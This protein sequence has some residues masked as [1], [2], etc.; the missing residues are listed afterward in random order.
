VARKNNE[1][2]VCPDCSNRNCLSKRRESQGQGVYYCSICQIEYFDY[3][4]KRETY[5][6]AKFKDSKSGEVKWVHYNEDRRIRDLMAKNA[7]KGTRN[8]KSEKKKKPKLTRREASLLR[9]LRKE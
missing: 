1:Y 3:E 9:R 8:N 6:L 2:L 5:E 7:M 4:I